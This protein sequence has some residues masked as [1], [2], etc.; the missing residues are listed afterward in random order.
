VRQRA[1]RLVSIAMTDTVDSL[2]VA[3]AG[4]ILIDRIFSA[5]ER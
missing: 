5:G 2:N 1:D 3:A 4:A